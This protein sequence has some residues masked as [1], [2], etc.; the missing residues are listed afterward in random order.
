LKTGTKILLGFGAVGLILQAGI[1]V[2]LW[3]RGNL[4][5]RALKE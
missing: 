5:A 2:F 3:T 4:V 1:V